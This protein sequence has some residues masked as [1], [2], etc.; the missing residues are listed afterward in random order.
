MEISKTVIV[1]AINL[2]RVDVDFDGVRAAQA[3]GLLQPVDHAAKAV[4]VDPKQLRI[5]AGG[6][7]P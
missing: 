2:A 5:F 3:R 7:V 1:G 6:V 4:A